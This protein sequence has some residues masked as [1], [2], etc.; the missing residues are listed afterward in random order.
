MSSFGASALLQRVGE[1]R[2]R[3]LLLPADSGGVQFYQD[4]SLQRKRKKLSLN[5][6]IWFGTEPDIENQAKNQLKRV[7]SNIDNNLTS[8]AVFVMGFQYHDD[9]RVKK[10]FSI[11]NTTFGKHFGKIIWIFPVVHSNFPDIIHFPKDSQVL[12][13]QDSIRGT[14]FRNHNRKDSVLSRVLDKTIRVLESYGKRDESYEALGE[15]GRRH[16]DNCYVDVVQFLT[17]HLVVETIWKRIATLN[18]ETLHACSSTQS[19]LSPNHKTIFR[20]PVV[21]YFPYL[22]KHDYVTLFTSCPVPSLPVTV[23]G[24]KLT[25]ER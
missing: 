2:Q 3:Y 17:D 11:A 5:R 1:D 16:G 19:I 24:S 21:E 14:V 10:L 6:T 13:F 9:F 4:L 18:G 25:T 23:N 8:G 12:A 20:V 7:T 22:V 15:Q